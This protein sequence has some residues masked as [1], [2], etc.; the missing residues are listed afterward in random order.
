MLVN[1]NYLRDVS[2]KRALDSFRVR[3]SALRFCV[4]VQSFVMSSQTIV[5]KWK[6]LLFT[7]FGFFLYYDN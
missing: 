3:T 7:F 2:F 5:R 1:V 4:E 6:H